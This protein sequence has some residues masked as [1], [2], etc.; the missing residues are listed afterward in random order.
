MSGIPVH[1]PIL[2]PAHCTLAITCH[3]LVIRF[4][5]VWKKTMGE[6]FEHFLIVCCE[7]IR[8]F[9]PRGWRFPRHFCLLKLRQNTKTRQGAE[10]STEE[11]PRKMHV[12][13]VSWIMY[14]M[15]RWSCKWCK[16]LSTAYMK[17]LC[18]SVILWGFRDVETFF[19]L[20][21]IGNPLCFMESGWGCFSSTTTWPKL[22]CELLE[23]DLDL[24]WLEETLCKNGFFWTSRFFLDPQKLLLN[25]SC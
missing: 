21:N 19:G 16:N 2:I 14:P 3:F 8:I 12:T 10:V 24:R 18:F 25:Y 4:F 23:D 17:Y 11:A 9:L 7:W 15:K 20:K 13:W 22:G 1:V 5:A 6:I